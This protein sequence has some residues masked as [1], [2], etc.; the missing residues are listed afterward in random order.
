MSPRGV[1]VVEVANLRDTEITRRRVADESPM[2]HIL[3][4]RRIAYRA[5]TD[6]TGSAIRERVSP[7]MRRPDPQHHGNDDAKGHGGTGINHPIGAKEN[8]IPTTRHGKE[9]TAG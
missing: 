8:V 2:R 3:R 1:I 4:K 5:G 9:S 6:V 7:R